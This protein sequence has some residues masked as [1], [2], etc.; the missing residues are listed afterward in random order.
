MKSDAKLTNTP[1]LA[2]PAT[3]QPSY[4]SSF[5]LCDPSL[6][7]GPA[8]LWRCPVWM[9]EDEERCGA[10]LAK[11]EDP[12]RG[13]RLDH[14]RKLL[15]GLFVESKAPS[16]DMKSDRTDGRGLSWEEVCRLAGEGA[17]PPQTFDP[18]PSEQLSGRIHRR[19]QRT[20]T[21][22]CICGSTFTQDMTS[23]E[24]SFCSATCAA[25]A[26]SMVKVI[27]RKREVFAGYLYQIEPEGIAGR[28]L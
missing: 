21:T 19:G 11:Y 5:S 25:K 12:A 27:A 17:P 7:S 16:I 13:L 24:R 20:I 14:P 1:T 28:M 22:E 15:P 23:H 3:R 26:A 8:S 9:L 10:K 2:A 6:A 4:D 18:I